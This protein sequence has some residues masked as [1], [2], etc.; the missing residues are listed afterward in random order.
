MGGGT[1]MG[2][3]VPPPCRLSSR[4]HPFVGPVGMLLGV[5]C[6][7]GAVV[8]NSS[9]GC[10]VGRHILGDISNVSGKAGVKFNVGSM[11]CPPPMTVEPASSA[12]APKLASKTL[13]PAPPPD[14]ES[15]VAVPSTLEHCRLSEDVEMDK[16]DNAESEDPQDV[17][18]YAS[19][20]HRHLD[21]R[22]NKLLPRS[23]YMNAQPEI[24]V[25]MRAIL[26]DWLVE[27]HMK[28]KLKKETLFLAINI[29][30]RYLSIS[31]VARRHLQL[32]G[33]VAMLIAAK[34]E[35]IY[36]PET[37][38][39]VYITDNACTKEDILSMEIHVL[40]A[41]GFN[42]CCPTAAH[43]HE[44]YLRANRCG[45]VHG[46]LVQ[47]LLELALLDYRMIRYPPSHLVAAAVLLSNKIERRHPSW[48]PDMARHTGLS[49]FQVIDCA[50]ELGSLFETA[51]SENLHAVK[52]KFSF[53]AFSGVSRRSG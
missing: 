48:P 7:T 35:E 22:E 45:E 32:L 37:P 52:R 26:V 36:P 3:A 42:L 47:Y 41:I 12:P 40:T 39:L 10:G 15:V 34:F 27:V 18:E 5:D 51:G 30:D 33:V 29:V 49:D 4:P 24:N 46:H 13:V 16:M 19:D 6:T 1:A 38:Q 9:Q 20:I 53:E 50:R 14:E 31:I 11:G 23:D 43:Y 28:Y 21:F 44:R 2:Q 8:H 25:K 17:A